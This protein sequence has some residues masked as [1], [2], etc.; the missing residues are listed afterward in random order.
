MATEKSKGPRARLFIALELPRAVRSGIAAWG[1]RALVDPALRPVAEGSLHITL[2]FLGW[3]AE[4]EISR[5]AEIVE[6][7][8]VPAPSIEL[9]GPVPRPERGRPRLFALQ[10]DSPETSALQAALQERLVAAQ[11][12]EPEKRPFWPHLTVARVRREERGS[13]RPAPVAKLPGALPK[14][15]LRPFGGVRLTLYR[16]Q[17]QPQGAQYTPLAQVELPAGGQQ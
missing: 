8:R 6:S 14:E 15:L 1:A 4:E 17:L 3:R 12:F 10:V 13:K 5:L 9:G 7:S 16:S 2:A 11:L